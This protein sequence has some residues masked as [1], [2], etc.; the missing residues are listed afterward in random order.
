ME[1]VCLNSLSLLGVENRFEED[2][3]VKRS[4]REVLLDGEF[5]FLTTYFPPLERQSTV[6]GNCNF[7][8]SL[9]YYNNTK[10]YYLSLSLNTVPAYALC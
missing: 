10:L 7:Y 4:F 1:E 9:L 3:F 5:D 6:I 2:K 8:I